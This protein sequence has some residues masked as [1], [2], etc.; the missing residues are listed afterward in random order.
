MSQSGGLAGWIAA[1]T[2]VTRTSVG[3]LSK[4]PAA[5]MAHDAR[6]TALAIV[7]HPRAR[8]K[9][10]TACILVLPRRVERLAWGAITDQVR[11]NYRALSRWIWR[12]FAKSRCGN[13]II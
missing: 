5:Q 1:A 3:R 4:Q 13:M 7:I 10:R 8:V 11:A 9:C 6:A 12:L 2:G